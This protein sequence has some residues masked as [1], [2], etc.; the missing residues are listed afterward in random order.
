[1]CIITS[2]GF[3]VSG[4]FIARVLLPSFERIASARSI[5]VRSSVSSSLADMS[6]S[7]NHCTFEDL[8]ATNGRN[9]SFYP[10]FRPL[11]EET[12]EIRLVEF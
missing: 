7:Q 8:F 6:S 4:D 11:L 12:S 5:S 9:F 1:M 10:E 2:T 3:L